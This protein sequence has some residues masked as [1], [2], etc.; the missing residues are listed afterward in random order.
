MPGMEDFKASNQ[1]CVAKVELA[2]SIVHAYLLPQTQWELEGVNDQCAF[3]HIDEH[4]LLLKL[5][6]LCECSCD[7]DHP[8]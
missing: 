3:S 2:S 7:F 5:S 1:G 6:L 8:Y 4:S